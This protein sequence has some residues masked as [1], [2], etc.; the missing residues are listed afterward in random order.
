MK[1][2]ILRCLYAFRADTKTRENKTI[3]LNAEN[4]IL[5]CRFVVRVITK[6]D[7]N[8]LIVLNV[9]NQTNLSLGFS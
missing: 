6:T 3:V 8:D 7:E 4:R 2:R 5:G 9:E 1:Q